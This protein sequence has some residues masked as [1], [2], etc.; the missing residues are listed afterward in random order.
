MKYQREWLINCVQDGQ[1]LVMYAQVNKGNE[2][3]K[4]IIE[5]RLPFP[6]NAK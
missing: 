1:C 5:N 4:V 3:K 6:N 2:K